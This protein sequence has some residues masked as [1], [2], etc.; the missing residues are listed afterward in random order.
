MLTKQLQSY[1]KDLACVQSYMNLFYIKYP[2][3]FNQNH[4][5]TMMACIQEV[6]QI[7]NHAQAIKKTN[8]KQILLQTK[9][10]GLIEKVN[11]GGEMMAMKASKRL[12]MIRQALVKLQLY[13]D[14]ELVDI[15]ITHASMESVIK[16]DRQKQQ[17]KQRPAASTSNSSTTPI[18]TKQKR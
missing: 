13:V 10:G 17:M 15:S 16:R 2:G 18:G 9:K 6:V 12:N 7:D 3:K 11:E 14:D 5:N 8:N 4:Y 1:R